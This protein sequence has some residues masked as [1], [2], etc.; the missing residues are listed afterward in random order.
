MQSEKM[1]VFREQLSDKNNS[2][3]M[4]E[5][6][7]PAFMCTILAGAESCRCQALPGGAEVP[8]LLCANDKGNLP[9]C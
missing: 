1:Q 9:E 6:H 2:G 4:L 3:F 5:V 7:R 8:R